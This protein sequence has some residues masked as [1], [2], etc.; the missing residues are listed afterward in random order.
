MAD[1]NFP[2]S[3]RVLAIRYPILVKP[4]FNHDPIKTFLPSGLISDV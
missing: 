4:L 3:P 2:V 1:R